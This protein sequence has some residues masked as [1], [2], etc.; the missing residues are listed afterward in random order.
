MIVNFACK[1]LARSLCLSINKVNKRLLIFLGFK[2]PLWQTTNG[3][4]RRV[5]KMS[6]TDKTNGN[7]IFVIISANEYIKGRST[8]PREYFNNICR[9]CIK[10]T[11]CFI[12]SWVC[13]ISD[14]QVLLIYIHTHIYITTKN[15]IYIRFYSIAIPW[16]IR[17]HAYII[18]TRIEAAIRLPPFCRCHFWYHF[19]LLMWKSTIHA[20]TDISFACHSIRNVFISIW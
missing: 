7:V 15:R 2:T 6:V 10:C 14:I 20:M 1:N 9:Y 16:L 4:P 11:H 5:P 8:L 18:L 3:R 17:Q 19:Y 13:F 12:S